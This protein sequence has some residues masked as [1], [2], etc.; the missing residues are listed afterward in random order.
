MGEST[1]RFTGALLREPQGGYS[2]LCLELDVASQGDSAEEAK[3]MLF[4]AIRLYVETAVDSGLPYLRPVPPED[5]P[6][7]TGTPDLLETFLIRVQVNA[8]ETA[9]EPVAQT[10]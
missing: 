5:D 6:V 9:R 2:A 8:P 7:R 1:H 4:E 3:S 10:A